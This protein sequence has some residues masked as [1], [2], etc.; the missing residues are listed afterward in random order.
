STGLSDSEDVIFNITTNHAPVIDAVPNQSWNETDNFEMQ[1]NATDPDSDSFTVSGYSQ[2]AFP[3]FSISPGGLMNFTLQQDDVGNHTLT[4]TATDVWGAQSSISFVFEVK[5][6]NQPPVLADIP[7]RR[8]KIN[9]SFTMIISAS[10]SDIGYGDAL[11]FDINDTTLFSFQPYNDTAVLINFTPNESQI[12]NYF[13]KV[14]VTDLSGASDSKDFNL[15]VD[16]NFIPQ[17]LL[18]SINATENDHFFFNISANTTDLDYDP[19][20][21]SYLLVNESSSTFPNFNMNSDGIMQFTLNKSD[22]GNHTLNI[23][24]SD[25]ENQSSKLI[26]FKVLPVDNPPVL[27]PIGN[28]TA[29]E[30]HQFLLQ[31]N[32]TDLENDSLEFVYLLNG[33]FPSFNMST[34]GLLNFTPNTSEIGNHTIN[35]TVREVANHSLMDWEIVRIEVRHWNH[36]PNITSYSPNST[37]LSIYENES[38][39]FSQT[40]TDE[41]N[42]T[43]AYAWLLDSNLTVTTAN[44]TYVPGYFAAGNHTITFIVN[45]SINTSSVFWNVTVI[46][47]N[48]PPYFGNYSEGYAEFLNSTNFTNISLDSGAVL[49]A[50]NNSN[51]SSS[52][53]FLSQIIDLKEDNTEY[54][55]FGISNAY[56]Y[57]T[58][59]SGTS[60]NIL[61]RTSSNAASWGNWTPCSPGCANLTS[62][63]Y[64][65]YMLNSCAG[66]CSNFVQRHRSLQCDAIQQHSQCHNHKD[67]SP[68]AST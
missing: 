23:T 29:Y 43:L 59:P 1:I 4:I 47:V 54:M 41:D 20:S 12:A 9:H 58:V 68:C 65:Q 33:S 5:N 62:Q 57:G 18:D 28:L 8:A 30:E 11:S 17:I 27:S 60:A 66:L 26:P 48:R 53:Q 42:D 2:N 35:I 45:D 37:N 67:F 50:S 7:N 31:L 38:I 49:L 61:L 64:V 63:R 13:F 21:F 56:Y 51:Y 55:H 3:S 44:W 14:N 24:V 39:D 40:S 6:V 19:L 46:N 10:D 34:S 16:Y 32:A 52:G 36:P 25:G 15:T 22:V